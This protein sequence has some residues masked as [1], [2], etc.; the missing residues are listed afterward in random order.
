MSKRTHPYGANRGKNV[1]TLHESSNTKLDPDLHLENKRVE[2]VSRVPRPRV[3]RDFQRAPYSGSSR[4][5]LRK[6]CSPTHAKVNAF[7]HHA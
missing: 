2:D 6:Y 7:E 4:R 3:F 1:C 5:Q